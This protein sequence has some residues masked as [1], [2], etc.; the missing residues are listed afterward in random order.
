MANIPMNFATFLESVPQGATQEIDDLFDSWDSTSGFVISYDIKLFCPNEMCSRVQNFRWASA[1]VW[2]TFGDRS[3]R[4]LT[5]LC[6][7]CQ[8]THKMFALNLRNTGGIKEAK[9]IATKIGEVPEF[10]MEP[11]GKRLLAFLGSA[12]ELFFKGRRAESMGMGIGAFG[13]YRR[14]VDAQKTKLFDAIIDVCNKLGMK[15][16]LV[17]QLEAAKKESQFTRA[18]EAI[19]AALPDALYIDGH[20]PLTLL[21]SALSKGL[22]ELS[23]EECLARAHAIRIVLSELLE[24][25]E[26]LV[27]QDKELKAAVAALLPKG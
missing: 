2:I 15:G 3:N 16:D 23:E 22:H 13:Y 20:N 17:A 25:V 21:Y 18:V 6:R 26:R 7:N 12:R 1:K 27:T 5:Y 4:F 8:Q 10:G 14:V 11:L 19:K 9:G 24:R